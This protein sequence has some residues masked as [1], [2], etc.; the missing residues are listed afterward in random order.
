MAEAASSSPQ[1]WG[2]PLDSALALDAKAHAGVAWARVAAFVADTGLTE[3]Q[4]MRACGVPASTWA[5][6]KKAGA[7]DSEAS[8]RYLRLVRLFLHASRVLV[9][10]EAARAWMQRPEPSL[11]GRTPLS[12]AETTFG[13]EAADAAL[14][15]LEHGV[16]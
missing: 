4:V 6:R 9:D 7:L 16:Y 11:D 10:I 1:A 15:R 12:L 5:R 2:L 3:Q 13:A 14:G 8:D